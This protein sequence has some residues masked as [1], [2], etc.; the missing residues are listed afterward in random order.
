MQYIWHKIILKHLRILYSIS[1]FYVLFSFIFLSFLIKF[2]R[3]WLKYF[4][5]SYFNGSLNFETK[6]KDKGERL[7]A[8]P[9]LICYFSTICKFLNFSSWRFFPHNLSYKLKQGLAIVNPFSKNSISHYF[10]IWLSRSI[11]FVLVA[12]IKAYKCTISY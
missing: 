4:S 10:R 7:E 6:L 5:I 11:W 3:N 2:S 1:N 9:T 8:M 12:T